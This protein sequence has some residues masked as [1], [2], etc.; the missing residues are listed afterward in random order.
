MS[1]Q[2]QFTEYSD[3]DTGHNAPDHEDVDFVEPA[4]AKDVARGQHDTEGD[5]VDRRLIREERIR[6]DAV[7]DLSDPAKVCNRSTVSRTLLA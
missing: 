3:D 4:R 6:L 1:L 7:R 2:Q 5:E